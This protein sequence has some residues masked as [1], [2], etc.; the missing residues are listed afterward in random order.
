MFRATILTLF[1]AFLSSCGGKR[2]PETP[3]GPGR[4]ERE[5]ILEMFARS[6]VPGRSGQIFV[7]AE[8]GNFFLARPDDVYRFMHGGPWDYDVEIPILFHGAPFVRKG[9]YSGHA[10]QQDIAPTLAAI[11]GLPP[12]TTM[13]GRV[14]QEALGPG[15]ERP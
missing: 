3:S 1:A 2:A 7:V 12:P 4:S 5:T 9:V 13:N 11:L 8:K 6:Y 15:S 14:L 10:R